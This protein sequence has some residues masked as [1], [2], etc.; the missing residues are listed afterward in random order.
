M[1]I[2]DTNDEYSSFL[3][4]KHAHVQTHMYTCMHRGTLTHTHIRTT[5][6]HKL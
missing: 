3:F 2:V 5:D 6:F 4:L 1:D